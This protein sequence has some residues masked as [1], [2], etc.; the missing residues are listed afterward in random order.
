MTRLAAITAFCLTLCVGFALSAGEALAQGKAKI[1]K[2][3]VVGA[4]MY[5]AVYVEAPDG[6]KTEPFGPNPKGM[7]IFMPNGRFSQ[8]LIRPDL[9]KF[10]S[11]DRTKG[12]PE[13]NQAA[14]QGSLAYFGTYTV[15]E[16]DGTL[17]FRIEASTYPNWTGTTQARLVTSLTASEM[18]FTNPAASTGGKAY[19]VLKKIP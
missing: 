5:T 11:N 7:F 3:Q 4:W 10:A 17:T 13:E 6:K 18:K 8:H 19:V 2:H 16:A 14:V 12:T 9:P 15:N 1:T